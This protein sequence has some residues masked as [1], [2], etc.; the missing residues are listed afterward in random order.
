ML[1]NLGGEDLAD[2][3][4]G[5]YNEGGLYGERNGWHLPGF[6]DNDW[7]DVN[8]PESENR[9]GVSW[10]RTTFDVNIPD[11]YDAPMSLRYKDDTKT[12]Y[13]TLLFVNG[14][15]MGRYANDLGPQTQYYLPKGILNTQ[16]KNTLAIG[17]VA[18]DEAAQL[19]EVVLEPYEVLQSALPEVELVDSPGYD[20]RQQS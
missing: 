5:T 16:G 19:G 8:I 1:G 17:V 12:R 2:P 11:G 9:T 6:P 4:R 20:N 14:W 18:I 7:E 10:Y 3:V 13:R 15:N